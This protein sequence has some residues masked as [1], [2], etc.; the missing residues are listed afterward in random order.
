MPDTRTV[1]KI[2]KWKLLTKRSLGRPKYRWWDNI[3]HDIC[4]MKFKT[5]S[6]ASRI[7]GNGKR[8]LRGPKLSAIKGSSAPE[9]EKD[10]MYWYNDRLT[11]LF[12][13][14][15]YFWYLATMFRPFTGLSSDLYNKLKSVLHILEFACQTVSCVV[16]SVVQFV[17][18]VM[19]R[20]KIYCDNT[21]YILCPVC[22]MFLVE[23]GV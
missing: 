10:F 8:S 23:F 18:V 11:Q 15:K 6:S 2:F 14:Y 20:W 5:G 12:T 7:G 3:K 9:E 22:L 21:Q 19:E 16:Y 4:Q 13:K 1:K 17:K